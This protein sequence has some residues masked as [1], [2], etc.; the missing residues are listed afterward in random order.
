MRLLLDTHALVWWWTDDRRLPS[1]ARAAVADPATLVYVSAASAWEIT[2]KNRVGKWPDVERIVT[3][4]V[5]LLRRSRFASLPISAEHAHLAGSL[6]GAHRD[7]FDRMLIA[8]ARLEDLLIVTADP[9]FAAY[10]AAVL[11]DTG[12]QPRPVV[13]CP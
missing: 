11:W 13:S 3:E 1:V 2:T 7:P 12:Q 5:D 4:Y 9:V 8:Q 6:A 10:G